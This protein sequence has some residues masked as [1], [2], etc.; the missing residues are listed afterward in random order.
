MIQ[1]EI[2]RLGC[3][4]A[5]CGLLFLVIG[6]AIWRLEARGPVAGD[7][8]PLPVFTEITR[9]AGLNHKIV[10]GDEV[11]EYLIDVNGQGACFFDYNNDGYQD[12]YLVNG[13]SRKLEA[14]GQSPHD[15]LMRN[16]GD[17]TFTDV[18]EAARLGASGW[19]SGCAVG[20]YNNDGFL[21][22]YVTNYGPNSL[23]PQ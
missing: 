10:N 2:F 17:G 22:I 12:L 19:H 18:T 21:D 3:R 6:S 9:Q 1:P 15:Y 5:L 23:Y 14:A 4:S 11:T 7:I 16:N 13:T 20:D 8:P